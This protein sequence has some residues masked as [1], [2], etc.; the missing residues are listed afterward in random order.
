MGVGTSKHRTVIKQLE[1]ATKLHH[2][3]HEE[4][5]EEHTTHAQKFEEKH[6]GLKQ[7]IEVRKKE[8][9]AQD[10]GWRA[11]AEAI[12]A[13]EEAIKAKEQILISKIVEM[14]SGKMF[15]V[16]FREWKALTQSLKRQRFREAYRTQVKEHEFDNNELTIRLREVEQRLAF[17]GDDGLKAKATALISRLG[18]RDRT[19][20]FAM[21][22]SYVR[23][24]I[25][26]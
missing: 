17:M 22:R 9:A 26:N 12:K 6:R 24:S 14:L 20:W 4:H 2:L 11:L 7:I 16:C 18:H 13:E 5:H 23:E 10:A 19:M 3:A 25:Y 15:S 8:W 1:A 21:W